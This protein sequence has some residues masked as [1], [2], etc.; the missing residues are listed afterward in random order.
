MES[1]YNRKYAKYVG[2]ESR[3]ARMAKTSAKVAASLGVIW[4]GVTY[5]S[6][7][8]PTVDNP[9]KP[10]FVSDADEVGRLAR[11]FYEHASHSDSRVT[12]KYLNQ[13]SPDVVAAFE[14]QADSAAKELRIPKIFVLA[15]WSMECGGLT[16]KNASASIDGNNFAGIRRHD[17]N[18]PM[19]FQTPEDFRKEYVRILKKE[20]VHD[21][22]DFHSIVAKLH[23]GGYVSGESEEAY[24]GKIWDWVKAHKDVSPEYRDYYEDMKRER[25]GLYAQ[26]MLR[27]E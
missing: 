27:R 24:E 16:A 12:I 26:L 8:S 13:E 15:H 22:N 18:G 9:A 2:D 19:I 3:V 7:P 14:A 21:M 25:S 11:V 20:G 23:R 4:I 6:I 10:G 1:S 5:G 17:G